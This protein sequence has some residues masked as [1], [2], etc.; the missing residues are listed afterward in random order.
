M[1]TLHEASTLLHVPGVDI[2]GFYFADAIAGSWVNGIILCHAG[3]WTI[4]RK[5]DRRP[6]HVTG[7]APSILVGND[8]LEPFTAY[9]NGEP[10]WQGQQHCVFKSIVEGWILCEN[11]DDVTPGVREPTAYLNQDSGTWSGMQ[12]WKLS[13]NTPD[14]IAAKFGEAGEIAGPTLS[15]RGAARNA[16]VETPTV[17]WQWK[18]WVL[19]AGGSFASAAPFGVYEPVADAGNMNYIVGTETYSSFCGYWRKDGNTL[20]RTTD[21]VTLAFKSGPSV[22]TNTTD[23]SEGSAWFEMDAMPTRTSI[24]TLKSYRW[25]AGAAG[26]TLMGEGPVSFAGW[27][28]SGKKETAYM[29]EV[30]LWR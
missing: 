22:W 1:S 9:Y 24:A 8:E 12:W 29:A 11:S 17:K 10:V 27:I 2:E 13:G 3:C 14:G 28:T 18:R 21:G 30:G 5:R 25:T 26:P 6:Y 23:R 7:L 19:R 16:G 20:V 4:L 15:A